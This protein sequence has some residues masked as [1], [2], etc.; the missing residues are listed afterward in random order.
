M[1]RFATALILCLVLQ[2]SS[3]ALQTGQGAGTS[4]SR[5]MANN[6]PTYLKL[7]NIKVG[8][9]TVHVKDFAFKRDAGVF[10]FHSG[11]FYFL[12]PV[13]GKI[14]GAIFT[15][16]ANF[17][18]KPP[19]GVEQRNLAILTKGQPFDEQFSGAVFRFTDGSEEEIRKAAVTDTTAAGGDPSG[20]LAEV[21]E[22]LKRTLRENLTARLLE[23]VLSSQHGG[24]FVA[25][26]KGTKYS[27]KMIYDIDPHGVSTYDPD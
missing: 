4:P 12:E 15:G 11:V 21:Q 25:F 27:P 10:T 19:L 14:T 22:Q 2:F 3:F 9:E 1:P 6:E 17:A 5:A 13:N 7:R 8:A 24:K 20:L 16:D 26:I 23:D 18:L